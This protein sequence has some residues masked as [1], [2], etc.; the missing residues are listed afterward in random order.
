MEKDNISKGLK[1]LAV[2]C[3]L[4]LLRG[5]EKEIIR[6]AGVTMTITETDV[7]YLP[8]THILYTLDKNKVN[9]NS[10]PYAF[11]DNK[12]ILTGSDFW[13]RL[14]TKTD[15]IHV[16]SYDYS[17]NF[18]TTR[19]C[20]KITIYGPNRHK[21]K[22]SMLKKMLY[23]NHDKGKINVDVRACQNTIPATTFN[24]VV[25]EPNI[26]R[27][28]IS[29]LYKWYKD[30]DW[31]TKHHLVHKIGV[32]LYGKPGTGKST[33]IRAI[34]TMFN[35]A[36]II[37]TSID[38]LQNDIYEIINQRTINNGVLIVLIE[39][40]DMICGDRNA[41]G[42]ASAIT[43]QNTKGIQHTLFQ[44][45]DGVL[46]L[47]D[48]IFVATTNYKEKLDPALIRHGRFDVQVELTEF[49]ESRAIQ[50]MNLFGYDKNVL[51]SF[52]LSY[53]IQPALLQLKVL[54]YK[55]NGG[56]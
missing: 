34:S 4:Q 55:M 22:R 43:N 36:K 52:N 21:I 15:F 31:Y 18:K 33:V 42:L 30:K 16:I 5:V 3:G 8:L 17:P 46:S 14:K 37:S 2:N 13:I 45:L 9:E 50:F 32:L 51:D 49:D 25:L 6:K 11:G 48:T 38:M 28:L 12:W 1:P 26:Q 35:N 23:V 40:I 53:P 41:D 19:V 47:E 29:S 20:L 24:N 27:L 56:N 54:E 39:D 44:L 7:G 10:H